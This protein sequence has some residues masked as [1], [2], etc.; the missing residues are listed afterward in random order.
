MRILFDVPTTVC[1]LRNEAARTVLRGLNAAGL[2]IVGKARSP[3]GS[4]CSCDAEHGMVREYGYQ[5]FPMG[6]CRCLRVMRLRVH[7]G[8]DWLLIFGDCQEG[9]TV[10]LQGPY[11]PDTPLHYGGGFW[12]AVEV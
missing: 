10:R 9:K 4:D 8:G 3:H 2:E 7:R 6:Q 12:E 1:E 5:A 11:T